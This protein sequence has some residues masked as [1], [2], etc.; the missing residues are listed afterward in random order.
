MTGPA[1]ATGLGRFRSRSG[2]TSDVFRLAVET[3]ATGHLHTRD[4]GRRLTFVGLRLM[5]FFGGGG[6]RRGLCRRQPRNRLCQFGSGGG[7]PWNLSEQTAHCGRYLN[8][9]QMVYSQFASSLYSSLLEPVSVQLSQIQID[10]L[11]ISAPVDPDPAELAP[12]QTLNP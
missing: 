7:T 2:D 6:G 5:F 12:P 9:I 4:Q 10:R 8:I 1:L 3:A 11:G